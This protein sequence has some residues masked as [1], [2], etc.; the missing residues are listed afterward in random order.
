DDDLFD[1]MA[2]PMERALSAMDALEAG[3]IAN[4]DEQR[5]VGHYWLRDAAR[6]PDEAIRRDI[7][8]AVDAVK[9]FADGVH[10]GTIKPQRGD[11]FFVLLVIGIGGSALGPR[12]VADALGGADDVMVVRFIDNTDPDGID[13]ILAELDESLEQTL[14]VVIS[15]SGRTKETRNAMLEVARAYRRAGLAF[16][17]HAV[18]VTADGSELHRIATHEKWLATLPMW[19]FVGGRTSEL[20]PVG[21]LPAA[22]HGADIDALLAGARDTDAA[23]RGHNIRENPAAILALMWYHA[24]DGRGRRNMV[25]LPYCDRLRLFGQYL[26]QLV[27]ESLGKRLDRDGRVVHQGLTVYGNK[28]ST[29]QHAYVQQLRDG[30]DDFFVTFIEIRTDRPA[31][32]ADRGGDAAGQHVATQDLANSDAG[33]QHAPGQDVAAF[34]VD[35][36]VT[37]GDYL[38]AFLHGT[39]AALFDTGRQS[40]TITLN[41]LTARSVGAIIALFERAV[42]LY[43]ELINVN[44][45]H[46]PG[47]E[48]GKRAAG[49][50]LDLQRS[51]L[52]HLRSQPGGAYTADEIATAIGR[53]DDAEMVYHI[54]EHAAANTDHHVAASPGA[55]HADTR[56]RIARRHP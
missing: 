38:N 6:A 14:T 25:V 22:L 7:E 12:F 8:S 10:T 3:A 33:V 17:R 45:Y 34:M 30:P 43:A 44:A 4:L 56:Y 55:T 15:K 2:E 51:V 29:D 26:Q 23:T 1:R 39:R 50:V 54:L 13:R 18:A 19:D 53:A 48:A 20:S 32:S 52:A 27:M 9:R 40:I 37:T 36:D 28:G 21:L 24:G 49:A 11:G 16:P 41:Q 35:D 46:Q 47:V 42:G 31:A 5:M